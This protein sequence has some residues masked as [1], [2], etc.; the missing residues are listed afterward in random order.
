MRPTRATLLLAGI[1]SIIAPA[2]AEEAP[3]T[4]AAPPPLIVAQAA[5]VSG[6]AAFLWTRPDR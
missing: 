1:L 5:V 4:A 2:R 6:V 3:Q